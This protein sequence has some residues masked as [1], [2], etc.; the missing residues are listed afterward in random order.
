MINYQKKTE[1][2]MSFCLFFLCRFLNIEQKRMRFSK[3]KTDSTTSLIDE[4]T[5]KTAPVS[6]SSPPRKD[7][8]SS[9]QCH[10]LRHDHM[11]CSRDNQTSPS[12]EYIYTEIVKAIGNNEFIEEKRLLKRASW[13]PAVLQEHG[14][15]PTGKRTDNEQTTT[16]TR[17]P[18]RVR[19][20]PKVARYYQPS[21]ATSSQQQQQ[22]PSYYSKIPSGRPISFN[23]RYE[24]Q[25]IDY[26]QRKLS[27]SSLV[28][29]SK[30]KKN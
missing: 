26:Q 29:T 24:R 18:N 17:N 30:R 10:T 8:Q 25:L 14:L 21:L 2:K 12:A 15:P 7:S 9:I 28:S 27:N 3:S 20:R 5:T 6:S 13:S 11:P 1:K 19:M 16:I 22:Q 4:H 23:E